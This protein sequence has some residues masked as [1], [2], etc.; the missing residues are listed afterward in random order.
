MTSVN[1]G[2]EFY[3]FLSIGPCGSATYQMVMQVWHFLTTVFAGIGDNAVAGVGDAGFARNAGNGTM[4]G[5][6]LGIRGVLAKVGGVGVVALGNDQH[7]DGTLGIDVLECEHVLVLKDF[8]ARNFTPQDLRKH[9]VVVVGHQI[10][11]E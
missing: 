11:P 4:Q 2:P 6:N 9:V 3:C 7:M 5:R 1:D 8:P 10:L